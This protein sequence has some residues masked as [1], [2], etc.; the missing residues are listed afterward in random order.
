MENGEKAGHYRFLAEPFHVDFTGRLT[1][2]VLGNHLLNC[3]GMHAESHGFGI[4]RLNESH[5]TWVL[6]RLAIELERM[7]RQ[8]EHFSIDTWIENVYR[9]FTD[10]NFAIT[11]ENG[12][13][14][15]YARSV[16]A[17]IDLNSRR[18]ADLLS[19]HG[20]KIS[21]YICPEKQCP[22]EKPGRIKVEGLREAG[23]HATCYSDIDINGH[24]N[25]VK[26]M[27]HVLDLL[28]LNLF[29]E[30]EIKRFEIAYSAESHYGDTLTFYQGDSDDENTFNYEIKKND[31]ETVVRTKVIFKNVN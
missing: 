2:G 19:L 3:A 16:W 10:R 26:Y 23:R 21:T 27:E 11:D 5:Y 22:I 31:T 4:A 18:P 1:L 30:K 15:G 12:N 20:G 24:V 28:P 14:A 17:M 25:S 9:L 13:V 8:Y 29:K 7:P 6:S